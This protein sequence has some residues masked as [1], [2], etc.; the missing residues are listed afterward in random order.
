MTD[1]H[2]LAEQD[3]LEVRRDRDGGRPVC[4]KVAH[5]KGKIHHGWGALAQQSSRD[6]LNP[7][8]TPGTPACPHVQLVPS[9]PLVG[10]PIQKQSLRANTL[11]CGMTPCASADELRAPIPDVR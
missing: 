10:I 2:A 4:Y 7:Q 1:L 11:I 6:S 8:D 9:P 3:G 5:G